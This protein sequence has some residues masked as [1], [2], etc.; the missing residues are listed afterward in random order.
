MRAHVQFHFLPL[1]CTPRCTCHLANTA[2][3]PT[4]MQLGHTHVQVHPGV[5][6]V[7]PI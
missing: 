3:S 4:S 5:H 6:H 1:V 7:V 2:I